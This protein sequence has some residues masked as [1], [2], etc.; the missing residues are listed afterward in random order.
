MRWW[1]AK[2]RNTKELWEESG[3]CAQLYR[4]VRN[5][6]SKLK[7]PITKIICIGLGKLNSDPTF[8]QSAIQHMT[9]FSFA[10]TLDAYNQTKFPDSPPVAIIAQDPSYEMC[11]RILLQELTKSSIDFSL[12][13]PET[14]L[15][16]DANTLVVTAFLPH[17]VPLMQIMADLFADRLTEGP[18]M[19]LREDRVLLAESGLASCCA[20]HTR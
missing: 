19:I 14:L 11:D 12:S 2:L 10:K 3:S 1:N 5:C 9:V 16:I 20:V 8:Y 7:A 4:I 18:A 13:D 17:T 6:A 15:A